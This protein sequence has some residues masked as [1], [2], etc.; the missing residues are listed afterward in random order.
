[1]N[2]TFLGQPVEHSTT[3]DV[4]VEAKSQTPRQSTASLWALHNYGS[5]RVWRHLLIY[6]E[7]FKDIRGKKGSL[8]KVTREI[9]YKIIS[10][11]SRRDNLFRTS[12][13]TKRH[14]QAS[15]IEFFYSFIFIFRLIKCYYWFWWIVS[16]ILY[17]SSILGWG[18]SLIR[19]R[20]WNLI[21]F[22]Y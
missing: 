21:S 1:M 20:R 16:S 18:I 7:K 9:K 8:S 17:S 3:V 10:K 6:F 4:V 2:R 22:S 12:T 15:T 5:H 14:R 13:K 11:R 19:D